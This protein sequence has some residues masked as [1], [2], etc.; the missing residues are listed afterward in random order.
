M[1]LFLT[2]GFFHHMNKNGLDLIMKNLGWSYVNNINEADIVYSPSTYL[3]TEQYPNKK[4]IFGP[5]FSVFPNDSAR[6]ISNKFNNSIYIQP[7]YPSVNTWKNEFNFNNIPIT[8][9]PFP[10]DFENVRILDDEKTEVI[11]YHKLRSPEDLKYVTNF[12]ESKN[13][14]FHIIKYGSYKEHDY[15]QLLDKTKYVVW[16]GAHESQGFALESVLAKNIPILVWST[17]LRSQE[18]NCPQEYYTVKSEIRTAPYWD[19]NCGVVFFNKEDLPESYNTFISK[20]GHFNP[21]KYIE[22]VVS[23]DVCSKNL[24]NI[25]NNLGQ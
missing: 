21:R 8:S 4:F 24:I 17:K 3:N 7:S 10:I 12:L 25:I 19:E 2:P 14:N 15:Q 9:F 23:I 18:Y 1:K 11:V 20:L 5:H 22:S 6:R 16:V 13:V